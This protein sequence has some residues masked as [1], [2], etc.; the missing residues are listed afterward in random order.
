MQYSHQEGRGRTPGTPYAGSATVDAVTNVHWDFAGLV[1]ASLRIY[2]HM[3][4]CSYARFC[5]TIAGDQLLAL[6]FGRCRAR[7]TCVL[8]EWG[9]K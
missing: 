9:P 3:T 2:C 1:P 4:C 8:L 7:G 6:I 5:L